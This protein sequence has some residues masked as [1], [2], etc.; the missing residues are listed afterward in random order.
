M[1]QKS[2]MA[3]EN[4]MPFFPIVLI[5]LKLLNYAYNRSSSYR[6]YSGE[7]GPYN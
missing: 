1:K 2:Y 5:M 4:A 7:T 3:F 6:R